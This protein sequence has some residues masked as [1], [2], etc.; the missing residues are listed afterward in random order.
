MKRKKPARR[1]QT[2]AKRI[3][4]KPINDW[5][6]TLEA[7][8]LERWADLLDGVPPGA[9]KAGLTLP[10]RRIESDDRRAIAEYLRRLA[11]DPRALKALLAATTPSARR[12]PKADRPRAWRAALEFELRRRET[13]F[14]LV[15]VEVAEAWRIGRATLVDA[16]QKQRARTPQNR[17]LGGWRYWSAFELLRFRATHRSITPGARREAFIEHL[18]SLR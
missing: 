2:G 15:A 5:A 6:A 12:G 16:W 18:R 14:E 8:R 11:G 4:A 7:A 10:M 9:H 17:E 3:S 13:K 1:Q